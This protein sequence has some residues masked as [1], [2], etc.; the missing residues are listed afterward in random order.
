M[1]DRPRPNCCSHNEE[2]G[3]EFDWCDNPVH[4]DLAWPLEANLAD[5]NG[6]H[7]FSFDD[8]DGIRLHGNTA[9]NNGWG[10]QGHNDGCS[11]GFWKT[12]SG[13]CIRG[14]GVRLAADMT[15]DG[16]T[17]VHADWNKWCGNADNIFIQD[18]SSYDNMASYYG[19]NTNDCS[20]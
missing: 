18:G 6:K 12:S 7:G 8:S 10:N 2:N 17:G 9:S 14:N 3:F 13:A 20:P 15:G 16:S 11:G 5:S 4:G 1:N 19:R